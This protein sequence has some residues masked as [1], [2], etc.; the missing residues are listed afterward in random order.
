MEQFGS[1]NPFIGYNNGMKRN[2]KQYLDLYRHKLWQ[3]GSTVESEYVDM[4][5][6][7]PRGCTS[8]SQEERSKRS[9]ETGCGHYSGNWMKNNHCE[10]VGNPEW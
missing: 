10:A 9:E 6:K 2:Q 8:K 7:N 1:N 5:E 3:R 4:K